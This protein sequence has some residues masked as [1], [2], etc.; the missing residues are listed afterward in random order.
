VNYQ[1]ATGFAVDTKA[2]TVTQ[3]RVSDPDTTIAMRLTEAQIDTLYED[4]L[5]Y[6]LLE[7]PPPGQL[8]EFWSGAGKWTGVVTPH[9]GAFQQ[10]LRWAP[11]TRSELWSGNHKRLDAY[12]NELQRMVHNAPA[13]RALPRPRSNYID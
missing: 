5:R 13:Y 11:W 1:D 7:M 3:D 10:S 12:V 4:A 8:S 6:R 2:G 9:A